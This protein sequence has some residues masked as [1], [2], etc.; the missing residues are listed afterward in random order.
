VV[1]HLSGKQPPAGVITLL[2]T[3]VTVDRQRKLFP[4]KSLGKAGRR[5]RMP[6]QWASTDTR[7]LRLFRQMA[8]WP[9]RN[10]AV[11]QTLDKL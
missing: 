7:Y 3:G 6:L 4:S 10:A 1:D 11:L 2:F 5:I 9:Y 8:G